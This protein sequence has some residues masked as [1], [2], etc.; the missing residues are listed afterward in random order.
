MKT[1]NELSEELLNWLREE[2]NIVLDEFFVKFGMT[3]KQ[4]EQ[5]AKRNKKFREILDFAKD[6]IYARLVGG[7]LTKRF[8]HSFVTYLLKSRADLGSPT[9]APLDLNDE[10]LK[11][12]LITM[13]EAII[14]ELYVNTN[15]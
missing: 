7:A 6:T 14:N 8:N 11:E 1:I 2:D 4:A 5:K 15:Q 12:R 3:M 13:A 10:V 9:D